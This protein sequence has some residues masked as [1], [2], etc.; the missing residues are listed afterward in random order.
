MHRVLVFPSCNEPGLETI[1]ALVKSNK[2]QVIGGSSVDPEFD[3]STAFVREHLRCP[4]LEDRGFCRDFAGILRDRHIDLVF[5]TT[6]ALVAEL[7]RW[8]FPDGTRFVTTGAEAAQ[9]FLSKSRTYDRLRGVV[10]VPRIFPHHSPVLPSYAKPDQGGGTR[11]H[12]A[13]FSRES[14]DLAANLRLLI[15]ELLPGPEY[16]VDCINDLSGNLLYANVRLRGR[17]GRGISLGTKQVDAEQI[18]ELV[19]KIAS[20]VRIEGPWFAQFKLDERDEP[21]LLEVN[22]RVAGSMVLTRASGVNIP[23]IAAFLFLGYPV[24]VPRPL[25]RVSIN[26]CLQSYGDLD[27]FKWVL[28]DLEDTILRKDGKPDPDVVS[29]LFDLEN[30]G[31]NQILLT[32]HPSPIELLRRHK[33]P[34]LFVEVRSTQD[35]VSEIDLLTGSLRFSLSDCIMINDSISERFAIENRHAD[36]RILTP[37]AIGLLGRERI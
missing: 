37:D 1:Q 24:R 6:D 26:R 11:G 21:R 25:C 9:L 7:S 33:L 23:Q 4:Y 36:L 34:D 16:T 22:A 12:M 17:I 5:P 20:E 13:I 19:A 8:S 2:F 32:K 31:K 10:P 27:N 29:C 3:P 15:T 18:K 28:W 14:W 30:R 35:K